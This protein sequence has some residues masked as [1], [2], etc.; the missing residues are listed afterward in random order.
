MGVRR[1]FATVAGIFFVLGIIS[2]AIYP[3]AGD[4]F[5]GVF[6]IL[7]IALFIV[8]VQRHHW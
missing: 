5:L 2:M 1:T 3:P 4:F 8:L 6:G 7:V